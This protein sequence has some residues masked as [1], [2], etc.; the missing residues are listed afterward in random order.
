LRNKKVLKWLLAVILGIWFVVSIFFY[1][2]HSIQVESYS[3]G[4][5]IEFENFSVLVKNIER[6]NFEE[7]RM[8]F[9]D[10]SYITKLNL[11][12]NMFNAI[13]KVNNF[14][15][16]P[17]HIDNEKLKYDINCEVIFDQNVIDAESVGELV[18]EELNIELFK[19]TS[20]SYIRPSGSSQ[21]I[22]SNEN[23]IYHSYNGNWSQKSIAGVKI[24]NEKS[25]EEHVIQF[26]KQ[27]LINKYNFFNP[28]VPERKKRSDNVIYEFIWNYYKQDSRYNTDDKYIE[29]FPWDNLKKYADF[30]VDNYEFSYLGHYMNDEQVFVMKA[31]DNEENLS[32]KELEFY[33]VYKDLGWQIIDVK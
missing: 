10:Y 22:S 25:G 17:Y 9:V 27:F 14:Y 3:I 29:N 16:I 2:Q 6:R 5:Y 30:T 28:V 4:K 23:I 26:D 15:S 24:I 7:N 8:R 18:R 19:N 13:Y 32:I 20:S 21:N 1:F 11:P 12:L 31:L 33:M